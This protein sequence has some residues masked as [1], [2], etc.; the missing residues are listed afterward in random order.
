[1]KEILKGLPI[2]F[3]IICS[4][5]LWWHSETIFYYLECDPYLLQ[6]GEVHYRIGTGGVLLIIMLIVLIISIV[7][8]LLNAK[9]LYRDENS[10]QE[11]R[12]L[13][14]GFVVLMDVCWIAHFLK[15]YDLVAVIQGEIERRPPM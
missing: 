14:I 13:S 6:D 3:N 2:L 8:I 1:M 10:K 11:Y 15:W 9:Y 4:L 7:W 12:M 5:V